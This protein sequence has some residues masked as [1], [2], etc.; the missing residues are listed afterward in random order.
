MALDHR[1]CCD[2]V[3]CQKEWDAL[4]D[5]RNELRQKA[6]GLDVEHEIQSQMLTR[7]GIEWTPGEPFYSLIEAEIERLR[8]E[9]D[10]AIDAE[11][12]AL[13]EIG[14]EVERLKGDFNAEHTWALAW[15]ESNE[16]LRA[17]LNEALAQNER[18]NA[19]YRDSEAEVERDAE[20][21]EGWKRAVARQHAEIDRLRSLLYRVYEWD[22][23]ASAADGSFWREEIRKALWG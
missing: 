11:K 2:E 17:A 19:R 16:Q 8:E 1:L 3:Q 21:I 22:H 7:L 6:S 20:I 15:Q 14:A 12:I 23:L 10:N 4:V 9:R 13:C 5:E 18:F